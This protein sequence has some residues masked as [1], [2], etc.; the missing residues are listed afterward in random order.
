MP[1][2]EDCGWLR[3]SGDKTFPEFCA[4][5]RDPIAGPHKCGRDGKLFKAK[6]D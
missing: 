3:K 2:C 1:K 5:F 4:A 6:T